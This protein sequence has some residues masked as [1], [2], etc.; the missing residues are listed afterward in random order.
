MHG[1]CSAIMGCTEY[2]QQKQGEAV[3]TTNKIS[4][5]REETLQDR[6]YEQQRGCAVH[7]CVPNRIGCTTRKQ[8]G[9][10]IHV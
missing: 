1:F 7:T 9:L 3:Q 2:G 6:L 4:C 10:Y 5:T 8:D